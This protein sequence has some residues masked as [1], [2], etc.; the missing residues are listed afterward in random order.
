VSAAFSVHVNCVQAH[1][2]QPEHQHGLDQTGDGQMFAQDP[3][4]LG[5]GEDEDQIEEQL[6]E[7]RAL[8]AGRPHGAGHL[9]LLG[10]CETGAQSPQ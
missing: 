3:G 6:D 10:G 1:H 8:R 7:R 9:A 5:D 2:N 4:D